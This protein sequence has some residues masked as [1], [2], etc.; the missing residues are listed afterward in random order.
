MSKEMNSFKLFAWRGFSYLKRRGLLAFIRR[1]VLELR[2]RFFPGHPDSD[3]NVARFLKAQDLYLQAWE[4]RLA[5]RHELIKFS[6]VVPVYKSDLALLKILIDS[7]ISQTYSNWELLLV[8]DGSLDMELS[9][10]LKSVQKRDNRI[11]SYALDY[12]RGIS[13]ATNFG[14]SKAS[15]D[16][17]CL[18]DHDDVIHPSSLS[19]FANQLSKNPNIGWIYSDEAKISANS[20]RIYDLFFKPDW[21]PYY[22]MT[23]MYTAHF[24]AYRSDLIKRLKFNSRFDG[25]QDFD[26]ALRLSREIEIKKLDVLH[27]PFILYFW[28]AIPGSTALSMQEKP[29]SSNTGLLLMNEFV[30]SKAHLERVQSSGFAGSYNSISIP[31]SGPLTVIIPTA[32]KEI[33][34]NLLL[35]ECISSIES[36]G[37]PKDSQIIVVVAKNAI[38][39]SLDLNFE[40]TWIRD[41]DS[42]VNIARKMNLGAANANHDVLVFVND[43]ILITHRGTLQ[44]LSGYLLDPLVGTVAPKLLY[45]DGTVQCAGV[46]F[47]DEGL[48]DHLARHTSEADPG[49]YFALVGQHEVEANTG[50]LLLVR[51]IIF[52][53]LGGFNELLPINYNDIDFCLRVSDL[54]LAN[55]IVNH[56]SALHLESA[57]RVPVVASLEEFNFLKLNSS[58]R[59]IF[60]SRHLNGRPMNYQ[61]SGFNSKYVDDFLLS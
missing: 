51:K 35:F 26:F 30:Q 48:P 3:E 19:L 38:I 20:Q 37:L 53:Q 28:R 15:G 8:D 4:K 44:G 40:I 16:F 32:L 31:Y 58:K 18:A 25:A 46:S 57:S 52:D 24:A 5:D 33:N 7:I 49:Y 14:L 55:I 43:D 39:P 23:C 36:S 56:I 1:L 34:G 10:Y 9:T 54:E 41:L 61:L 6:I 42:D 59:K 50:A 21:S 2:M 27:I 47:N 11:F 17:I 13:A 29:N 22:L 60:Y 12:N 45:P